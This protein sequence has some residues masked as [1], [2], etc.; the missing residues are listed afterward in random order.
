MSDGQSDPNHVGA[1]MECTKCH[2]MKKPVGRSAAAEMANSLCD[3]DCEGYR[4]QPY[5]SQL[6]PG[7]RCTD[8]GYCWHGRE[9]TQ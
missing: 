1:V 3:D 4:E 9:D 5:P 2:R 8:F 6:W 7:E